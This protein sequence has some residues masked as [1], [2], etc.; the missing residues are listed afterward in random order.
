MKR[1]ERVGESD[2][3]RVR[4]GER[5]AVLVAVQQDWQGVMGEFGWGMAEGSKWDLLLPSWA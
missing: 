2:S 5:F 3:P 4:P 1:R